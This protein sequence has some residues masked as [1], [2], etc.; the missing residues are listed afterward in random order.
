MIMNHGQSQVQTCLVSLEIT[1]DSTL[2]ELPVNT[3]T[4][5]FSSY[6]TWICQYYNDCIN[7]A[8][9]TAIDYDDN[10]LEKPSNDDEVEFHSGVSVYYKQDDKSNESAKIP[11]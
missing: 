11:L 10:K 9:A 1:A 8:F 2:P 6:Y 5:S 3:G 7:Y 4:C